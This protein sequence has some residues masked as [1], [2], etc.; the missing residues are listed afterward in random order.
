MFNETSAELIPLVIFVL[1]MVGTPGPANLLLMSG[2]A[3]FGFQRCLPFI[4]GLILGKSILNISIGF[5]LGTFLMENNTVQISFKLISAIF[6]I[7]LALKTWNRVP[8]KNTKHSTFSFKQGLL[9]HPLS[10]KS[11]VMLVLAWTEYS[12]SYETFM[13]KLLALFLIFFLIQI[14]FH[15]IYCILGAVIGTILKNTPYLQK[16]M[17]CLTI[18]AVLIALIF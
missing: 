9:I 7:Y 11:W 13:V 3:S 2:G 5:G 6:M 4:T 14:T 10:P 8:A 12:S 1:I 15:T 18:L 16:F 17:T